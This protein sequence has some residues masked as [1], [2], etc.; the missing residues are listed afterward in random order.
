MRTRRKGKGKGNSQLD[1]EENQRRGKRRTWGA[2]FSSPKRLAT[3]VI[4]LWESNNP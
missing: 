3:S 1:K 2:W 4:V